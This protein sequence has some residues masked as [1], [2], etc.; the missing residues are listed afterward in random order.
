MTTT[1]I[2]CPCCDGSG[3]QQDAKGDAENC[4]V[5]DGGGEVCARCGTPPDENGK[6]RCACHHH[7][8][9]AAS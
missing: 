6:P 8:L 2:D 5:C 1:T 3:A 4:Q 7:S 9:E